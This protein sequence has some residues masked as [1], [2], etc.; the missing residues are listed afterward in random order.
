MMMLDDDDDDDDVC[1]KSWIKVMLAKHS[2]LDTSS[3]MRSVS[4]DHGR[5]TDYALMNRRQCANDHGM[6]YNICQLASKPQT[7]HMGIINAEAS[8]TKASHT[9]QQCQAV[10]AS[11]AVRIIIVLVKLNNVKSGL[12]GLLAIYFLWEGWLLAV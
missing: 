9:K 2:L 5:E 1:K 8:K 12:W 6:S 3:Q 10:I 11:R 7:R 4:Q